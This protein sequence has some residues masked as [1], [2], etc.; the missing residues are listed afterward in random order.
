MCRKFY[1]LRLFLGFLA[2]LRAGIHAMAS[3]QKFR[4]KGNNV[5]HTRINSTPCTSILHPILHP[6]FLENTAGFTYGCRKCRIFRK[7]F[8]SV[9]TGECRRQLP[10]ILSMESQR[11][12]RTAIVKNRLQL[13]ICISSRNL[14]RN[15]LS[16]V[17]ALSSTD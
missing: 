16:F 12:Y 9:F 1:T 3:V 15:S 4:G 2:C 14:F 17:I 7:F 8:L 5:G 10:C 11:F 13:K 6:K